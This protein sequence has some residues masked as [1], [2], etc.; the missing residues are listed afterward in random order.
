MDSLL[1]HLEATD[2]AGFRKLIADQT[3]ASAPGVF[4]WSGEHAVLSGGVGVCQQVSLRVWVGMQC[5]DENS[6]TKIELSP[7]TKHHLGYVFDESGNRRV[8]EV[9]MFMES[10]TIRDA[11]EYLTNWAKTHGIHGHFF[12]RTASE[13]LPGSGCN[14]SGAFANALAACL[15]LEATTDTDKRQYFGTD[16]IQRW[17]TGPFRQVGQPSHIFRFDHDWTL[18]EFNRLAWRIETFLHKGRAS[19][20]GTLCSAVPEIGPL[21]YVTGDRVSEDVAAV[22]MG[23]DVEFLDRLSVVAVPMAAL[24]DPDGDGARHAELI[25]NLP[26]ACGLMST[27]DIKY[28]GDAIIGTEEIAER[29]NADLRTIRI[30]LGR[31]EFAKVMSVN[32]PLG[33][34]VGSANIGG[35]KPGFVD[36]DGKRLRDGQLEALGSSSL[37]VFSALFSLMSSVLDPAISSM[38]QRKLIERLAEEMVRNQGGLA[39]IGV[40]WPREREVANAIYCRAR[41]GG[42]LRSSAVKLT[43]GGSGGWVVF[44]LPKEHASRPAIDHALD[45]LRH[46]L[47]SERSMWTEWLSTTDLSVQG[48]LMARRHTDPHGAL[49]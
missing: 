8:E 42:F 17:A 3:Q 30:Q 28:T 16:T 38:D 37:M 22:L 4:F 21:L 31:P 39:Q 49:S 35:G 1:P 5:K 12:V 46:E 18:E 29:L 36:N 33:R 6:P 43:G 11:L 48:G 45:S 2:P 15:L 32:G 19:G 14:W 27:G 34:L 26:V 40:D 41:Q 13:I 24:V 44:V 47:G 7:E 23:N 10:S 25:R 20:Y 9:D